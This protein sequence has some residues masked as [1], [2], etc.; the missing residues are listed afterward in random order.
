MGEMS[1]IIKLEISYH[2][3]PIVCYIFD[4]GRDENIFIKMIYLM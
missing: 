3:L 4:G 2:A 1:V